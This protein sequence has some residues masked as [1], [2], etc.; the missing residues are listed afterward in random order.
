MSNLSLLHKLEVVSVAKRTRTLLV[1]FCKQ[2][3]S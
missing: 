2:W 3:P 1:D